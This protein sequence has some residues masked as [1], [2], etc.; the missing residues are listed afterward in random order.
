MLMSM[1][2]NL[3]LDMSTEAKNFYQSVMK[4]IDYQKSRKKE[5]AWVKFPYDKDVFVCAAVLK[6][7]LEDESYKVDLEHKNDECYV[8]I[9]WGKKRDENLDESKINV[10]NANKFIYIYI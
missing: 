7:I 1:I 3:L 8:S 9:S 10:D 5:E 4:E 6:G 2:L